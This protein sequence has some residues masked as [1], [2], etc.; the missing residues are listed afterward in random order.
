VLVGH[1]SGLIVRISNVLEQFQVKL[2]QF[3]VKLEQTRISLLGTCLLFHGGIA[4]VI[5][6][7]LV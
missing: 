5:M 3:R 7:S 2:E 6:E 4:Q 1:N